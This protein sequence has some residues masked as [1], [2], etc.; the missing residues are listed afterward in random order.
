[1]E[2]HADT[3]TRDN[4]LALRDHWRDC[5]TRFFDGRMLEPYITLTE[6]SAPQIY[7]QCC[8]V[9]SWGSRLEIRI[10]PSLL[11]GTHPR[12][13]GSTPGR[14]QFVKDVLLHE[15]IHQHIMEHQP[16]VNEDSYHGHG[17]VF[18]DYCNRIGRQL[19]LTE[20]V[21]RN[22]G[23]NK[24]PKA[25][26]WPHCVAPPDRYCGAYQPR[27]KV[28]TVTPSTDTVIDRSKEPGPQSKAKV[29]PADPDDVQ[30]LW[31]PDTTVTVDDHIDYC[32]LHDWAVSMYRHAA[33]ITSGDQNPEF[34]AAWTLSTWLSMPE[35]KN[36]PDLFGAI[37]MRLNPY[38][39]I[40]E[41]TAWIVDERGADGHRVMDELNGAYASWCDNLNEALAEKRDGAQ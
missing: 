16:D 14:M 31:S 4:F 17:P 8:P 18:T 39:L 29:K 20:V 30:T 38:V 3:T 22:R 40:G 33:Q 5:N 6:P 34:S 24:L 11:D 41:M 32:D 36:A 26:Q 1:V 12:M 15:A 37:F 2:D 28:I 10:R 9:S 25:A 13:N 23:G 35:R 7:G 19:G 27:R 21:V